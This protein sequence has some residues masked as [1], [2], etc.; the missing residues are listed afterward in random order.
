MKKILKYLLALVILLVAAYNMVYFKKLNEVKASASKTFD[1]EGYAKTFV[2]AK[3][4]DAL[5]KA[6]DINALLTLLKSDPDK[7]FEECGHALAIGSTRYFLIK[8]KGRITAIDYDIVKVKIGADNSAINIA[9]DFVFGNAL[10]D[11]SHLVN[12]NA[13]NNTLDLSNISAEIN[14][15]I[16]TRVLPPFK[17]KAKINDL[18]EFTGAI[19]LNSA[20][21]NL[22]EVEIIPATLKLNP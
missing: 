6:T 8:G 3:L 17:A 9:T 4:P 14:K 11:A 1:A 21:L 12:I 2:S 5:K 7:A 19:E 16:R 18:V 10:R 20:H 15:I 13:F 22:D